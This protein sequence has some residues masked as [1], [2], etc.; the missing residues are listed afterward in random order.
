MDR[1]VVNGFKWAGCVAGRLAAIDDLAAFYGRSGAIDEGEIAKVAGQ[2][3]TNPIR[4]GVERS[5][6]AGEAF[7]KGSCRVLAGVC[8]ETGG[9]ALNL[10]D[11]VIEGITTA[12]AVADA[13][14][15]G[16]DAV[17]VEVGLG[18]IHA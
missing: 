9:E 16:A 6:L 8:E 2:P 14:I 1:A 3:E 15:E 10:F 4:F 12:D 11:R 5:L 13:V 18:G 17:A 7:A